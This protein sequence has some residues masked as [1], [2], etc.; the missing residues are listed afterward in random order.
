MYGEFREV[1]REEG[2]W[3]NGKKHGDWDSVERRFS[4]YLVEWSHQYGPYVEGERRGRWAESEHRAH[5]SQYD[6]RDSEAAYRSERASGQYV[7]GEREGDWVMVEEW[8]ADYDEVLAEAEAKRTIRR[9]GAFAE[10]Q[11][12]GTWRATLSNGHQ[13]VRNYAAGRSHGSYEARDSDGSLLVVASFDDG[14]VTELRLPNAALPPD[15]GD[16]SEPSAVVGAFGIALGPDLE[17]LRQLQCGGS[18]CINTA[19][20]VL[21]SVLENFAQSDGIPGWVE[22]VPKPITRGRLYDFS[23][24][25]WIGISSVTAWLHFDSADA[26]VDEKVRIDGLLREKYGE[27]RD[28]RY[29]ADDELR[30]TVGQ[31]DDNGLPVA[32]VRSRCRTRYSEDGDW[33]ALTLSYGVLNPATREAVVKAWQEKGEVRS[34]EL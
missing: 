33:D 13:I 16:D 29:A 27:C 4:S 3:E 7:D 14:E 1:Q 6:I 17:Q 23:V 12:H 20:W 9:T 32:M 11:R 21:H 25:P 34:S 30:E 18:S 15:R 10:G 2:H 8:V 31:C 28:Y 5:R 19:F 24:S 26:C 22:E